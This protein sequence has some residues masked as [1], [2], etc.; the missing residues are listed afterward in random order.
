MPKIKLKSCP[1]CG[2]RPKILINRYIE[3]IQIYCK[4]CFEAEREDFRIKDMQKAL[5]R[6]NTRA[7]LKK[8][9]VEI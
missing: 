3:K 9:E 8:F 7:P 2:D 6:W 4:K 5:E 1:F